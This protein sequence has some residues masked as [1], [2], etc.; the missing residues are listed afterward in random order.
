MKTTINTLLAVIAITLTASATPNLLIETIITE[1]NAPA[2]PRIVSRPTVLTTSGKEA[3]IQTGTLE[4]T[5]TATVVD[6]GNIDVCAVLTDKHK[7]EKRV[8]TRF[9]TQ[10]KLGKAAKFEFGQFVF[11]TKISL[12]K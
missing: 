4:Y 1:Q 12:A 5:V 8:T 9:E 11:Q 7:D 2:E 10:L 6:N 3:I